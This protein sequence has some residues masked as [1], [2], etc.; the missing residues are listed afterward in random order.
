M[1]KLIKKKKKP[2]LESTFKLGTVDIR[3]GI[4]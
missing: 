4:N 1:W 3:I 2:T